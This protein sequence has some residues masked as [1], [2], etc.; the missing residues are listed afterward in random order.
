MSTRYLLEIACNSVTSALAAQQGG[1][2]RIELFENLEQGGTTPSSGSIAVAR[3]KLQIPLF[4]LIRPRPGD[5]HY[6]PLETET[7]LRDIA[8]CRQLGCDG[9]VI[10]GLTADGDID[11][12]LCRELVAAAGT[13]GI[14]F[15][16]AFDT[17][18]DLPAALEQV[19]ELGCE[20]LLSSGGKASAYEGRAI[21]AGLVAQARGRIALMAGAGLKADNIQQVARDSGCQELHASAKQVVRSRMLPGTPE[22]TGLQS[23]W[24]QTDPVLVGELR[25]KLLAI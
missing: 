22:L 6:S 12:P 8:H 11:M 17:A 16:R 5:F 18:R 25:A 13:M 21:L 20:R 23:D 14:T 4:V 24:Q 9:V 7:M 2:N 1:A 15:H 10:G 3:D 19:I